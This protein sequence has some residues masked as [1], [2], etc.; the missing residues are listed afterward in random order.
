M[1]GI[2]LLVDTCSEK[3]RFRQAS[4]DGAAHG[5]GDTHCG[6]IGGRRRAAYAT[7][8]RACRDKCSLDVGHRT[9]ASRESFEVHTFTCEIV[10]SA[11]KKSS[12]ARHLRGFTSGE[13]KEG[14]R[15]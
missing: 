14:S 9:K 3:R 2:A 15:S 12:A 11:I 5:R 8:V 10:D 13:L 1:E 6:E 4:N 7:R